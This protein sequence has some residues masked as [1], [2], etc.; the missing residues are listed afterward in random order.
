M[1]V[2]AATGASEV[3]CGIPSAAALAVAGGVRP[4]ISLN[5]PPD[6]RIV[7]LTKEPAWSL[8]TSDTGGIP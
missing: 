8:S 4:K 1:E 7:A 6:S 5:S 3:G 2:R